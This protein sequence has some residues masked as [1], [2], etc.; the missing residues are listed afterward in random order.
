M[1]ISKESTIHDICVYLKELAKNHD[2]I[3]LLSFCADGKVSAFKVLN[4]GDGKEGEEIDDFNELKNIIFTDT[5]NKK[6]T[7]LPD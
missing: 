7:T 5:A 2:D 4:K 1:K 3:F 6:R